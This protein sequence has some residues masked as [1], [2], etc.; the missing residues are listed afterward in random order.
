MVDEELLSLLICPNCKGNIEYRE[1]QQVIECVGDCHYVYPVVN[2]I[3]HMLVDEA[4]KG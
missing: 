1:D 2:G 3:P 4:T